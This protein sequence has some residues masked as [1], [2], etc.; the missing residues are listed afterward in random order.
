MKTSGFGGFGARTFGDMAQSQKASL[1]GQDSIEHLHQTAD[2]YRCSQ[3]RERLE[4]GR[5]R[6]VPTKCLVLQS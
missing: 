6:F 5:K 3:S 2:V 4:F 1:A